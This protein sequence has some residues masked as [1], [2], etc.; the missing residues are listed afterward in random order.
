V[1]GRTR[2]SSDVRPKD[3]KGQVG[4]QSLSCRLSTC[5]KPIHLWAGL[6]SSA[7]VLRLEFWWGTSRRS[8]CKTCLLSCM[9]P[10]TATVYIVPMGYSSACLNTSARPLWSI[11]RR[12]CWGQDRC[13]TNHRRHGCLAR[14]FPSHTT[15]PA[16]TALL[17]RNCV[18]VTSSSIWSTS[19]AADRVVLL[20]GSWDE[21][22]RLKSVKRNE[23]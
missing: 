14:S 5:R 22:C 2:P 21:V 17:C 7:C 18:R 8:S 4:T 3:V 13:R 20:D 9:P 10:S 12:R 16:S 1:I 15:A 23:F 19:L 11:C 6:C